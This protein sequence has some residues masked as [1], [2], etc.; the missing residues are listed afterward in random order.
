MR[1]RWKTYFNAIK[2]SVSQGQASQVLQAAEKRRCSAS[3]E[4]EPSLRDE[5]AALAQDVR[6]QAF[7]LREAD[8][9]T[10]DELHQHFQ[11]LPTRSKVKTNM[12]EVLQKMMVHDHAVTFHE[13][14]Y[15][16]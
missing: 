5:H 12:Y 16:L 1:R 3:L 2:P 14:F 13:D 8:D 4:D 6:V 15:S 9:F 11:L 10:L 7:V